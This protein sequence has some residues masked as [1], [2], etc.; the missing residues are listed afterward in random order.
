M[1]VGGVVFP[2]YG[3]TVAAVNLVTDLSNSNYTDSAFD[4]GGLLPVV[5]P[6]VGAAQL[7]YDNWSTIIGPG[8]V[9]A[10]SGTGTNTTGGYNVI[11]FNG[12]LNS[13]FGGQ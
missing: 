6:Y 5:G 7:L 11:D 9:D 4:V 12:T 10:Y 8:S 2:V 13:S 3:N 1:Y